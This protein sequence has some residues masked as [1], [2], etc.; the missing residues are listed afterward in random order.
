MHQWGISVCY[1]DLTTTCSLHTSHMCVC[2]FVVTE[3]AVSQWQA[4]CDS[5]RRGARRVSV[6]GGGC[7]GAAGGAR[8]V[9]HACFVCSA[10]P[11]LHSPGMKLPP[12]GLA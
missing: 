4:L 1:Q 11:F 9:S 8:L 5:D 3:G 10:V 12:V 7:R 6:S 2:V